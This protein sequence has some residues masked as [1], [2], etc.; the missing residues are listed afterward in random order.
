MG[1]PEYNEYPNRF[2]FRF[3]PLCSTPLTTIIQDERPRLS[4]PNDGW[5]FYPTPNLAATVVVEHEGGIVMLRRA[6]PPDVGIWHLPIGHLEYG[7]A[8]EQAA[9]REV[10]EETGLQIEPPT[11]LDFIHS[12]SY[13]DPRMLYIVFCYSARSIGGSLNINSENT[14]ARVFPADAL[15]DLKW[16]SQRRAIAAWQGRQAGEYWQQG[17]PA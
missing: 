8:P 16:S 5:V 17:L 6:I 11:F 1:L 10:A 7:E 2:K 15:P 3:C 12:P 14:E 4:C 9:Q 13:G